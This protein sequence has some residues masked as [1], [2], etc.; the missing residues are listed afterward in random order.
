M[1]KNFSDRE[2]FWDSI[3]R[4]RMSEVGLDRPFDFLYRGEYISGNNSVRGLN[5][6]GEGFSIQA[7]MVNVD[8]RDFYISVYDVDLGKSRDSLGPGFVAENGRELTD[9]L[10]EME[11]DWGYEASMLVFDEER[12]Y[13]ASE[14]GL[15]QGSVY[16]PDSTRDHSED[17]YRDVRRLFGKDILSRL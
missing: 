7:D 2:L 16:W 6:G 8:M 1:G 12:D 3:T 9:L 15:L 17:V 13:E 5:M 14:D 11:N 4:E 10:E